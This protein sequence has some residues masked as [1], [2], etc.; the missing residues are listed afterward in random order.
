VW[1]GQTSK[2]YGEV[3]LS[4]RERE[5]ELVNASKAGLG[6]I[7]GTPLAHPRATS[8]IARDQSVLGAR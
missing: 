1:K 2:K 7:V 6:R 5:R 8:V 3:D 4:A